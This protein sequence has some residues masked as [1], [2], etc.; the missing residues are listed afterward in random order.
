MKSL[1]VILL[2]LSII[3]TFGCAGMDPRYQANMATNTVG[4]GVLGAIAGAGIAAA[5]HGNVGGGAIWGGLGGAALGAIN[6]PYPGAPYYGSSYP[7]GYYP[8]R[9]AECYERYRD[10]DVYGRCWFEFRP[11]PCW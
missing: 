5:T 1:A 6:T 8:P 10:C 7:Y 11:A 2:I 3:V 9:P 4:W